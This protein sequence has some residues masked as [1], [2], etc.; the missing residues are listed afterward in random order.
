[1]EIK[2]WL[3]MEKPVLKTVEDILKEKKETLFYWLGKSGEMLY[4]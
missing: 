1:M 3:I 4:G 2:R